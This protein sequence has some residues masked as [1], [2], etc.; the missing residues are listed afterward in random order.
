MNCSW[1]WH[2]D[3]NYYC[4]C[5]SVP[6]VTYQSVW[7][8]GIDH[9]DRCRADPYKGLHCIDWTAQTTLAHSQ[10]C[11]WLLRQKHA[12]CLLQAV[13]CLSGNCVVG[14][15]DFF[16]FFFFPLPGHLSCCSDITDVEATDGLR[17]PTAVLRWLSTLRC[18]EDIAAR[19]QVYFI[20]HV[21]GVV[22]RRG[23]AAAA[24]QERSEM[25]LRLSDTHQ[26]VCL[27]SSLH[28]I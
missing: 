23:A 10:S 26:H 18:S 11:F 19:F 3:L 1:F 12:L 6:G 24:L 13:R 27:H 25:L 5:L 15:C 7:L 16:F 20:W 9:E 21:T 2:Q 14:S 4:R 22:T 28:C 17:F 8:I